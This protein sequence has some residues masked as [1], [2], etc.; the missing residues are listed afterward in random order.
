MS[1]VNKQ[2]IY[3]T[4]PMCSWCYGFSP[5]IRKIRKH[6]E[7]WDFRL[8]MGGLRPYNTERIAEM[9][10]FLREHWEQVW[11]RSG[12]AFDFGILRDPDFIYDTEPPARAT[13]T[14]RSLVP[15]I[16][17]EFFSE[18]QKAFYLRN[19]DT[20]RVE[21]YHQILA[22]LRLPIQP[23]KFTELFDSKEMKARV[24]SDFASAAAL[25]VRG[26]PSLLINMQDQYFVVSRGYEKAES[27]VEYI[28]ETVSSSD[29]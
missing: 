18:V 19:C 16:E 8:V 20:G 27:I 29:L 13:V 22:D 9:A 10:G 26:F 12:Q 14:V 7:Q 1:D 15:D 2:I 24:K 17:F 28:E 6:F 21:T 23:T 25:G 4:D 11:H 5:E 3:V